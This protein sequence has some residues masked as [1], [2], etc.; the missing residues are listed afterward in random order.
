ME[1]NI[2]KGVKPF[3]TVFYKNCY[4]HQLLAGLSI[5][6][7][8]SGA[9][10][11]NEFVRFGKDFSVKSG[12]YLPPSEV[13]KTLGYAL[14]RMNINLKKLVRQIDRGRPVIVGVDNYELE[15]RP[16][17][18]HTT[19]GGHF[20]LV[21]GYD[22]AADACY[23][24]D[25]RYAQSF[26]YEEKVISLK[27]LLWANRA[28]EKNIHRAKTSSIALQK[29]KAGAKVDFLRL[30]LE[31]KSELKEYRDNVLNNFSRMKEIFDAGA[32]QI[33]LHCREMLGFVETAKDSKQMLLATELA[34]LGQEMPSLLERQVSIYAYFK[35]LLHRICFMKDYGYAG[36]RLDS[37]FRKIDAATESEREFYGILLGAE[38]EKN[39]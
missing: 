29:R 28:Y 20:V 18:Y 33:E 4:N 35:A 11:L 30:I 38:E 12:G 15:S 3:N 2:L 1:R 9:Y 23:I 27:N 14:K 16:D 37:I 5:L 22:L 26:R 13:E 6:G 17:F 34:G 32:E 21:Y 25:H 24:V 19:H 39:V 31:R 8:D 36:K 7:V 10:L